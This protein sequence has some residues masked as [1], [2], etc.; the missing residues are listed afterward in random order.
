VIECIQCKIL[1]RHKQEGR[2][3]CPKCN[4]IQPEDAAERTAVPCPSCG[5]EHK[6]PK[7]MA[8]KTIKCTKCRAAIKVPK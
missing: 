3:V 7:W 2:A 4:K 1:F 5:K 6:I 8:G